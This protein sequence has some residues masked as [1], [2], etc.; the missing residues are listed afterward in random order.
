MTCSLKPNLCSYSLAVQGFQ[1]FTTRLED[2]VQLRMDRLKEKLPVSQLQTVMQNIEKQYTEYVT[3]RRL[4]GLHADLRARRRKLVEVQL[5]DQLLRAVP[6]V[7][8]VQGYR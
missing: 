6:Q 2:S 1:G 7:P 3:R 5:S 8:H 4:Q